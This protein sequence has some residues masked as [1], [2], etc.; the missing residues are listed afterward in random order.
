M[1]Y[2]QFIA[3]DDWLETSNR[4]LINHTICQL[5]RKHKATQAHHTSYENIGNETEDDIMAL[6][7]RCHYHIHLAPPIIDDEQQLKK[8][9]NLMNR[10]NSQPVVKTIVLNKVADEFYD[11]AYML[12]LAA[13]RTPGTPFFMQNLLEIFYE[14]GKDRGVDIIEF[15]L[16]TAIKAKIDARSTSM[17]KERAKELLKKRNNSGEFEKTE[18]KKPVVLNNLDEKLQL[19]REITQAL[20]KDKILLKKAKSYMNVEFYHGEVFFNQ[21]GCSDAVSFVLKIDND[22]LLDELAHFIFNK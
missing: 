11:G 13:S 3:S 1:K 14:D 10:L 6:C 22:K 17:K 7:E 20:L 16:A 15:A 8:A 5:C 18:Y 19:R 12:E 9:I 2:Q 4:F 21:I